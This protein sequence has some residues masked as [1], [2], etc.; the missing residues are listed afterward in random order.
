MLA[1]TAIAVGATG[2]PAHAAAPR[3]NGAGFFRNINRVLLDVP[4]YFFSGGST[5]LCVMSRG[6]RGDDVSQLQWTLNYCYSERLKLDGD[7]GSLT[8]SALI[9]A[10]QRE[11]VG[12]DGVYGPE[13][14]MA[15]RFP[16]PGPGGCGRL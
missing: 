8:R 15:M 11:R 2:A 6:D 14:A 1:G 3:C 7:F 10:Q 12:A 13:T 16:Q 4:L 5:V 9:R